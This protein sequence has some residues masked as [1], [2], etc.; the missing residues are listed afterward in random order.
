MSGAS[1]YVVIAVV[2]VAL[3]AYLAARRS[4]DPLT[5][6]KARALMGSLDIEAFRNL[7]D[8]EEE[9]LSSVEPA[10]RSIQNNQ[11]RK[12][13]GCPRLCQN[14]VIHC[15]GVFPFRSCRASQPRSP[16]SRTGAA[17]CHWCDSLAP[18]CVG[19]KWATIRCGHFPRFTPTLSAFPV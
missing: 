16:R 18:G 9:T 14:L 19:S 4:R 10:R 7:V 15:L 11:T 17:D 8:P 12:S 5:I 13:P 6:D 1:V 3:F 2:L